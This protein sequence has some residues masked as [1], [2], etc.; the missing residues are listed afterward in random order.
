MVTIQVLLTES[1]PFQTL[2]GYLP[3]L[4]MT[5]Q[6]IFYKRSAKWCGIVEGNFTFLFL[7]TR[8]YFV[9]YYIHFEITGYTYNPIGSQQCDLF[10][11]RTNFCSVNRI[12]FSTNQNETV[13]QTTN[14]I[15][16]FFKTNQSHCRKMKDKK[17]VVWQ[18]WHLLL[19]QQFLYLGY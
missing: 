5:R 13:K 11:N 12:F 7:K 19:F 8:T 17:A 1:P 10:P 3:T 9:V 6:G 16:R 15:S 4:P 14:K 18:I 2:F